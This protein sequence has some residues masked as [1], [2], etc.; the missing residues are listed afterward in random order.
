MLRKLTTTFWKARTA[1]A[2]PRALAVTVH[3]ISAHVLVDSTRHCQQ[4]SVL[5]CGRKTE[6]EFGFLAL[7]YSSFRVLFPVTCHS[8][9]F[10]SLSAT[11]TMK[12]LSR[13]LTV[14]LLGVFELSRATER[15]ALSAARLTRYESGEVHQRL[16]SAKEVS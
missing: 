13:I 9:F 8:I 3:S 11:A 2:N 5:A 7:L 15:E 4:S 10:Q 14:S 12:F 6:P 1:Q 16:R